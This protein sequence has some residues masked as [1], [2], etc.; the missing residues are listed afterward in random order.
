[1][2]LKQSDPTTYILTL[3]PEEVIV[4][5]TLVTRGYQTLDQALQRWL[6]A[7]TVI[8][9]EEIITT[10]GEQMRQTTLDVKIEPQLMAAK[11]LLALAQD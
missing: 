9:K 5:D 4:V 10:V 6:N 7:Q 8:I 11:N 1:M 2:T 3:T